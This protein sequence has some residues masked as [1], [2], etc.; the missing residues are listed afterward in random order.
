VALAR[1]PL[2]HHRHR[3]VSVD[4]RGAILIALT[5]VGWIVAA[6][7]EGRDKTPGASAVSHN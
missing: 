6:I 2:Q 7:Y 1:R 3:M 4:Y 5:P